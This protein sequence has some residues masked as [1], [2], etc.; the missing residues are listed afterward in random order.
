MFRHLSR[1][2]AV[3][4]AAL[5]LA[6]ALTACGGGDDG[7]AEDTLTPEEVLAQAKTTLDETSGLSIA[8]T[9]PGL[10]DGVQGIASATGVITDA[11]AF[12]G[13]LEVVLSGT[14]FSVPVIAVD[15]IVNA[16]L[17]LTTG[18]QDI[19]P[20]DYNAPDPAGLVTG[21]TGF[22]GLLP[23]TTEVAEGESVRGGNNNEEIL[24]TYTGSVPGTAMAKVI[25]ST[26]GDTFAATY[27]ITEDGE[28]REATFVGV[29]YPASEEMTYT[30]TFENYGTQ[31]EITAP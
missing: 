14:T 22:S 3:G 7:S 20:E 19:D 15:D 25:P 9:T 24:T 1:R 23:A 29:F 5:L 4:P 16:Q 2:L 21:E 31:K 10:P 17:P 27:E 8:L 26:A 30:V 13:D 28:L 11:P 12:D 18:W 6:L